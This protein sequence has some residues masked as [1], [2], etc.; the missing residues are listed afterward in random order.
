VVAPLDGWIGHE[1]FADLVRETNRHGLRL[2]EATRVIALP[3]KS[4]DVFAF[5]GYLSPFAFVAGRRSGLASVEGAT[6]ASLQARH[7]PSNRPADAPSEGDSEAPEP[8]LVPVAP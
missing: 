8:P 2:A 3:R 1:D 5:P 7:G 4:K 6:K